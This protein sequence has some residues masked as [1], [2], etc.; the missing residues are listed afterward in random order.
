MF[1]YNAYS[2]WL[3]RHALWEYGCIA[4]TTRRISKIKFSN[5]FIWIHVEIKQFFIIQCKT[6][7][8]ASLCFVHTEQWMV[9][10]PQQ[11]NYQPDQP[12]SLSSLF[13][14]S[15][16]FLERKLSRILVKDFLFDPNFRPK[17]CLNSSVSLLWTCFW[18]ILNFDGLTFWQIWSRLT[19]KMFWTILTRIVTGQF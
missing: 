10:M 7:K 9:P 1:R 17:K 4:D 18:W 16:G 8:E 12:H 15:S 5:Y 14:N 2:E 13:S 11:F 3:R 6:M 19:N